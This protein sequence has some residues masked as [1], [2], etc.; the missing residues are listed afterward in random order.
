MIKE[1]PAMAIILIA[2]DTMIAAR[3]KSRALACLGLRPSA[4]ISSMLPFHQGT[5]H[6]PISQSTL[7]K[8]TLDYGSKTI[9]LPTK[10]V[11]RI[12]MTSL[13]TTFHCS[14]PI[15]HERGLNTCR[16]TES[17]VGQT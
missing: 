10:P 15:Q 6:Q 3:T 1:E 12:M 7:G 17:R 11:V 13:S 9:D 4:D 2:V 14:W 5:D 16:P 8:Q